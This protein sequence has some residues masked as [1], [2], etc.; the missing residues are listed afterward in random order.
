M[1]YIFILLLIIFIPLFLSAQKVKIVKVVEPTL[2][3]LN[4]GE[5]VRLA[6]IQTPDSLS[7]NP[8]IR[9]VRGLSLSFI[10]KDY[11]K[12]WFQVHYSGQVDSSGYPLVHLTQKYPLNTFYLSA[13]ILRHGYGYYINNADSLYQKKYRRAAIEAKKHKRGVWD[14]DKYILKGLADYSIQLLGGYI[15]PEYDGEHQVLNDYTLRLTPAKHQSG[16]E[17]SA[18]LF[19]ERRTGWLCCEC[20]FP[21]IEPTISTQTYYGHVFSFKAHFIGTYLG[22][23]LGMNY[24]NLE[25][26]FCHEGLGHIA[27][28]TI[29][30]KIGLMKKVYLSL[31]LYNYYRRSLMTLGLNYIFKNPANRIWLGYGDTEKSQNYGFEAQLNPFGNLLLIV[32]GGYFKEEY[33]NR[34]GGRVG[35]G[36]V[37]R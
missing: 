11:R 19:S 20:Y 2:F 26:Q 7:T 18:N 23:T 27:F 17:L 3:V 25:K 35:L 14:P 33:Q 15:E 36:W 34:L 10:K 21:D 30:F 31:S 1:K 4:T 13:A 16:L 5:W 37:L 6:N 29:G 12:K 24:I 32:Q 22:F 28:P 8:G 9:A